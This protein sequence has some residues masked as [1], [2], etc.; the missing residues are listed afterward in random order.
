M[1]T[2]LTLERWEWP[3]FI[4]EP[5]GFDDIEITLKEPSSMTNVKATISLKATRELAERLLVLCNA[6]EAAS[7]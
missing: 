4:A 7:G 6:L 3:F 5:C 1:R 2:K